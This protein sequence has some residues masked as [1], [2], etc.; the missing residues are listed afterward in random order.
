MFEGAG[1]H[2]WRQQRSRLAWVAAVVQVQHH[3]ER[4][5]GAAEDAAAGTA[6]RHN[7][8]PAGTAFVDMCVLGPVPCLLYAVL[9]MIAA[10]C[11][12]T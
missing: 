12:T 11:V 7:Y 3:L 10:A 1:L 4:V 2:A 6:I 8:T 9:T 5:Q